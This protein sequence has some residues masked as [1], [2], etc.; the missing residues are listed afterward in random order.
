MKKKYVSVILV[1]VM[2]LSICTGCN[3]QTVKDKIMT[4]TS[5]ESSGAKSELSMHDVEDKVEEIQELIDDN[6]YFGTDEAE[7][8]EGIYKGLLQSLDDPYSVYYTKEEFED[9]QQET[10]GE[11]VGVGVQVSQDAQTML[12]TVTRVFKGGP[13]EEAGMLKGDI[14]TAVEDWEL[15]GEEVS[16]VVEKIKGEEGTRVNVTVYRESVKDYITLNM[17]RRKVENPTVSYEMLSDHIGYIQVTDF[18]D[19]TKNQYIKAIEDLDSQGMEGLVVDLRDNPG[20][21][22]SAVVDM[23]DYMLPQGLLVYTEDKNGNITSQF[24]SSDKHQFTKPV[25]VLVNGN[26]ASASEIFTGAMQDRG[27]ATIIGTTTYGK[28]IVQRLFPLED[29]SGVKLTISKYFTPN[30]NDIHG[31]GIAPDIEIDLPDELK[32]KSYL[33]HDEDVQLKKAIEE[34]MQEIGE[35][36][37]AK[38]G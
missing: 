12:I 8:D 1:V 28:G 34:L 5:T 15:N 10:S 6:F 37:V 30:G 22:L 4:G 36:S 21:L 27:A 31:K 3:Y 26:S 33:E 14:V 38:A 20:G 7:F 2:G 25:T 17:E 9:L 19:V 24:E 29:G 16:D 18:Y 11:Y 13:A 23:L 32:T 35:P